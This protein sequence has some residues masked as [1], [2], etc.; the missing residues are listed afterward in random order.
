[1]SRQP[2]LD[3]VNKYHENDP[4]KQALVSPVVENV[5]LKKPEVEV[6]LDT[7]GLVSNDEITQSIR[8]NVI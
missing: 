8:D 1:M 2:I 6:A 4:T 7:M 3:L 5:T